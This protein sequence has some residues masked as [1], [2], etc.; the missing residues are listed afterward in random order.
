[1]IVRI[2]QLDRERA[3][4]DSGWGT[5]GHTGPIAKGW[6][7]GV[8]AYEVLILDRDE[9]NKPLAAGFRQQQLRQ[10][11]PEAAAALREPGEQ[12]VVRLDGP[13][14]PRQLAPAFAYLTES[15][16]RGRFAVSDARKLDVSPI[17]VTTSVRLQPSVQALTNLCADLSLG[18]EKGVRLRVFAVP[19]AFVNPLLDVG[20]LD[21]ERWAEILPQ[22]GFV[23]S[24][25]RGLRAFHVLSRRLAPPEMRARLTQRL[26]V[27]SA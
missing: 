13:L 27:R 6:P 12:L 3:E 17:D 8:H 24:T 14:A 16:G 26:V 10:L 21:D 11:I 18:L 19:E 1:V 22:C 7:Q 25:A 23:L 20:S 4:Q 5:H 2:N 9:L 15:D